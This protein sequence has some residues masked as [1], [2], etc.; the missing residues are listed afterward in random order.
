MKRN[1]LVTGGAGY[2]GSHACKELFA[3]GFTPVT[4]DNLS[5]G[6]K[7]S[8]KWGPLVVG[9][10]ANKDE[11]RSVIKA[12]HVEAVIHFAAYAYVE[13]SFHNPALYFQNNI[14]GSLNLLQVMAELQVR[15]LVFSSTCAVYGAPVSIPISEDCPTVPINPYGESKLQV[16]R[17][18]PWFRQGHGLN[19]VA[20]RYFNAAGTDPDGEIG[21][22]H[23]PETHLLPLA[24]QSALGLRP[25]LQIRGTDYPTKDGTAVRDFVHVSDLAEAHALALNYLE[26]GGESGAFNLGTGNGY[27]IREI[28]DEIQRN[29]NQ[30]L[31]CVEMDRR[32]GD[33]AELVGNSA[34][35]REALGWRPRRSDLTTIVRTALQW[36]KLQL[37][38]QRPVA[39]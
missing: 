39:V 33:P 30:P 2:I 3:R 9:D 1:I 26:R 6:N 24:I 11:L 20:L 5:R 25:P 29:T 15:K 7:H 14:A 31:P 13:E 35:A 19:W 22:S 16:E 32:S 36:E 10:L 21:E 4:F 28:I 38:F 8:V 34:R 27:S 23:D 37:Q 12:Y 17:L 18:F